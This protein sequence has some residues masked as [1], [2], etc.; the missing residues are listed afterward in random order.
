MDNLKRILTRSPHETLKLGRRIGGSLSGGTVVSLEGGLGTG[1]TVIAK[2]IAAG[3]GV[4]EEITSPSFTI[5]TEYRGRM[6]LHHIDLYR[7][8]SPQELED[9]GIEEVLTS[10]G[11]V[12][13]EWGEKARDLLPDKCIKIKVER[14]PDNSRFIT[15][16][17]MDEL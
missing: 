17:G 5:M 3:L 10:D 1:K 14:R 6:T 9:L 16:E 13:V 7:I 2:G 4:D 8:E 11:V 12:V 15:V